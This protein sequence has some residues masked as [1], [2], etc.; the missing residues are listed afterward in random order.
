MIEK[1]DEAT[2]QMVQATQ[3]DFTPVAV[4][5]IVASVI[6]FVLPVL[7]WKYRKK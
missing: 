2:G 6:S 1:L 7:N 5:W 4:F 3:Y